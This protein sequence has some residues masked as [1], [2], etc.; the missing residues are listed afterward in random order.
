VSKHFTYQLNY[1]GQRKAACFSKTY[2][3]TVKEMENKTVYYK[4]TTPHRTINYHEIRKG[5]QGPVWAVAPLIMI[6]KKQWSVDT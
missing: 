4:E 2:E 5:G 1:C 6:T 3:A